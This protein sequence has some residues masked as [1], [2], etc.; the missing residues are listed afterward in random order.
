MLHEVSGDILLSQADAIA[1]G[2]AANDPMDQG[3][4][5]ALHADYRP[6]T[7]IIIIGVVSSGAVPAMPGFG[8]PPTVGVS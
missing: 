8:P 3:L 5:K 1:H 4:A 7:G 6:C 2:L